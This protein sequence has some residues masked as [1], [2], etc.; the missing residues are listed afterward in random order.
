MSLLWVLQL[1]NEQVASE[2]ALI[3]LQFLRLVNQIELHLALGGGFEG[4]SVAGD[5]ETTRE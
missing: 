3:E 4:S 2:K 5:A 1:E